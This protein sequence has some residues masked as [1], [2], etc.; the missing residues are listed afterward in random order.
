MHQQLLLVRMVLLVRK[1]E[2]SEGRLGLEQ[3]ALVMLSV[4]VDK[5]MVLLMLGPGLEL[6]DLLLVLQGM[7]P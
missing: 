3:V 5:L 7:A 2:L 1:L 4:V 6:L